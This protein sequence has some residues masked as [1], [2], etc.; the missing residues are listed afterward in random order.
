MHHGK[1]VLLCLFQT[2]PP[3]AFILSIV[4][5]SIES[6]RVEEVTGA[7]QEICILQRSLDVA[8]HFVV[9]T[10]IGKV[11]LCLNMLIWLKLQKFEPTL[12]HVKPHFLLA[13]RGLI[14]PLLAVVFSGTPH[15]NY[16]SKSPSPSKSLI[17][18][19]SHKITVSDL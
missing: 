8:L 9:I 12:S 16:P 11:V 13:L 14:I 15:N 3:Q 6:I 19:Q 17:P 4:S 5:D 7:L 18:S 1:S 2:L 10:F